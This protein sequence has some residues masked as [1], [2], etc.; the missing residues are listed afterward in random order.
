MEWL[1]EP[2]DQ[3]A[4]DDK[5]WMTRLDWRHIHAYTAAHGV[6]LP[7]EAWFE[8]AAVG[9]WGQ[10][11]PPGEPG[12]WCEVESLCGE[13]WQWCRDWYGPYSLHSEWDPSG[14]ESPPRGARAQEGAYKVLRGAVSTVGP[15][16]ESPATLRGGNFLRWRNSIDGFRPATPLDWSFLANHFRLP[17]DLDSSVADAA[18]RAVD[19]IDQARREAFSAPSGSCTPQGYHLA[20]ADF[21]TRSRAALAVLDAVPHD[22]TT[23]QHTILDDL[24]YV[25]L[26]R[27]PGH[28]GTH[29]SDH[30]ARKLTP[31]GFS[32]GIDLYAAVIAASQATSTPTICWLD[33]LDLD[34]ELE[35]EAVRVN[36]ARVNRVP[37]L[38]WYLVTEVHY[39]VAAPRPDMLWWFA[40]AGWL[41][42]P[43][44]REQAL[45]G[46]TP[47]CP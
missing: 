38:G 47:S 29:A 20:V 3:H 5:P 41:M 39:R 27:M 12:A 4:A 28:V 44:L 24:G 45:A 19:A 23:T 8:F 18:Q 35:R 22:Q 9:P 32:A 6:D 31:G 7:L 46:R 11:G 25:R 36:M 13:I 15:R 10:A 33:Q 14:L 42:S 16:V 37:E 30:L 21:A 17:P 34:G 2:L 40:R 43:T 1:A 26:H